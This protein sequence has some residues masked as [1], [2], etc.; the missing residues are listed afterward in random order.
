MGVAG[1]ARTEGNRQQP[2]R[3]GSVALL[4][5][6]LIAC[7]LSGPEIDRVP[8]LVVGRMGSWAACTSI[9]AKSSL[10]QPTLLPSEVGPR[11]VSA[12]AACLLFRQKICKNPTS[13]RNRTWDLQNTRQHTHH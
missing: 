7:L 11:L 5:Q 9:W 10:G 13:H 3:G 4:G 2:S 12:T 1:R 8:I 6:R